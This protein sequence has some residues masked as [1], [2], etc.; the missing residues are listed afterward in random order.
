MTSNETADRAGQIVL[1]TNI[2][3]KTNSGESPHG[4]NDSGWKNYGR[5]IY[6]KYTDS[7]IYRIFTLFAK[8]IR[9]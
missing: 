4:S 9:W 1:E 8:S 5:R 7:K 6:T 2:I 3:E